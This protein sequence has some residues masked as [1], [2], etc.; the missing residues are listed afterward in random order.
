MDSVPSPEPATAPVAEP[1]PEPD[2]AAAP[3][4]GPQAGPGTVRYLPSTG[5]TLMKLVVTG[6][7]GVGKT[8]L[9]RTLSEIPTLHTEEVM[10]S[11]SA[12]LDD[13]RGLPEKSTTTVA[14]DFGRLTVPG[15]L[16]LY[17]FGT[18][19]QERFFPLWQDIARG[20]LGALVMA[21]TRR[22]A[23][24]FPV[25]DMVEEQGL[26]YAVAVNRF[27]G[28]PAHSDEVLRKHLDLAPETPLVQCDARNRRDSIGTLIALAEY[29][30]TRLPQDAP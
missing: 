10:T 12:G 5:Q 30:L 6:P 21:D 23:D 4:T 18:P 20:A 19:G 2:A 8:T 15:D 11:S 22:L 16:V 28:A 26:P 17:L 7:F 3:A 13:L 14:V 29:V 27:P 25:M 9:I 24:S 1:R